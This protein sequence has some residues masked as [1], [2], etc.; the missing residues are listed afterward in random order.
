MLHI[1]VVGKEAALSGPITIDGAS[2]ASPI[3]AGSG[4]GGIDN[5]E[6]T[7]TLD[8]YSI[9]VVR[10]ASLVFRQCQCQASQAGA[11]VLMNAAGEAG[12]FDCRRTHFTEAGHFLRAASFASALVWSAECIG[13]F[14]FT[15]RARRNA[16]PAGVGA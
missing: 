16:R 5:Y 13:S 3:R 7:V 8:L 11:A 15:V 10:K 1:G 2:F 12:V 6:R 9:S 14:A 4:G